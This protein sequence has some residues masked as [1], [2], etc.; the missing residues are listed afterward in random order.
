MSDLPSTTALRMF[1]EAARH[2]SFKRAAANLN[3]TQAAISKQVA[4]L[5]DRIGRQ[6]FERR[7]RAVTLTAAGA[8][9]LPFAEHVVSLLETGRMETVRQS[10]REKLVVIVD[11]EFLSFV[12]APRLGR[13]RA[14]LPNADIS[15][16]PEM[17]RRVFPNCD[18]AITFGHPSDSGFRSDRLC[19]FRAFAVGEPNLIRAT[20]TPLQDLP[21]LHDV[22]TYWWTAILNAENINRS[23]SG[24]LMGTG[25]AAIR[26]AISGTGLAIGDSL[27]CANALADG[28]LVRVGDVSLP[29]RVDYW[30]SSPTSSPESQTAKAFR[31]FIAAQMDQIF[32]AS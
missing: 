19:A 15:F 3:V 9:Y 2:T 23:T 17:G 21:L 10:E 28:S 7:H 22:D 12:L 11:H 13:L 5:E 18:L 1:I 25:A 6:L 32:S 14:A 16:V 20:D 8:A 31:R 29:G 27:L 26:G 4:S 24:I 30:I